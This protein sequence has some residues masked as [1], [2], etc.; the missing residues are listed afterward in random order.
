MK[1]VVQRGMTP[2]K[3]LVVSSSLDPQSRSERLAALCASELRAQSAQVEL[4]SLKD[5]RLAGFDNDSIYQSAAYQALH[6]ATL[7]ADGLVLASPVY[8]WGG[9][10]ELKKYIE[11]IGSTPPDG[12]HHGAFFDK[13]VTFVNA[14]GLPHSYMA[15]NA[16]AMSIMMDFKCII[17]P[18]HIYVHGQHWVDDALVDR[19]VQRLQKSLRVAMELT[20]LLKGRTY[21]STWEI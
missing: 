6:T 20:T 15:F 21:S 3:F 16:L 11:L 19:A 12:T 7:E 5:Y 1:P 2:A 10:A 9:S 18:Y 13:I 8:N 14:A 17:N 4:V